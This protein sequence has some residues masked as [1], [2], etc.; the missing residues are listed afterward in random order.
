V[1]ILWQLW[2]LQ[3][4]CSFSVVVEDFLTAVDVVKD[5]DVGG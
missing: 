2:K 1:F 5:V 3:R 4:V